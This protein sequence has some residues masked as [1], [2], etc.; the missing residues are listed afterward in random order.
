MQSS[1]RVAH[2]TDALA[3]AWC[4]LLDLPQPAFNFGRVSYAEGIQSVEAVL[5]RYGMNSN[6]P[7]QADSK[8]GALMCSVESGLYVLQRSLTMPCWGVY[9]YKASIT[10]PHAQ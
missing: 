6:I 2:G 3:L 4:W 7:L 10:L 9:E 8:A 5:L 1:D